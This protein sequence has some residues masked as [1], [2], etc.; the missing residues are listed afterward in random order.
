M[1][2]SRFSIFELKNNVSG[3]VHDMT[4]L[5]EI[6]LFLHYSLNIVEIVLVKH[7]YIKGD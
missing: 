2:T 5:Q 3:I 6:N 4:S 7:L 1:D